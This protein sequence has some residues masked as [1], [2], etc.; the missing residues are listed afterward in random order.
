MTA[1]TRLVVSIHDVAPSTI[2]DVRYLLGALD[3]IGARPRVLK[4]IPNAGG[5]QDVRGHQPLR[6]LLTAEVAAGSEVLL[7]GYT[8]RAAGPAR[9]AWPTRA[10][11]RLFGGTAAEFVTL[12]DA[13]MVNR[14]SDGRRVL[15]ECGLVPRGFCAPCWLAPAHLPALLRRCGFAYYVT[16][17]TLLDVA[18]GRRVLTPWLGY[19]GA[20]RAQERLIGL[21]ARLSLAAAPRLPVVKVFLHPQGAATSAACDRVLTTLARL[22]RERALTTFGELLGC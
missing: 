1:T 19:M 16:M 14:L 10:R 12:D 20:G 21:G 15:T 9:G 6:D 13:A 3:S 22:S 18:T 4:V 11:A 2:D 17:M 7:H 8:H 5:D